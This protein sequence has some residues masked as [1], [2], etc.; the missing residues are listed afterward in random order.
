MIPFIR[1]S[2]EILKLFNYD[3]IFPLQGIFLRFNYI[4][5]KLEF[6]LARGW[7]L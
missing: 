3:F 7:Y 5:Q 4:K 6:F 2:R 1:R